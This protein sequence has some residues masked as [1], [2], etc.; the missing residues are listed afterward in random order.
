MEKKIF[1]FFIFM[2]SLFADSIGIV[3]N[4]YGYVE[5]KRGE[6]II[7]VK[8]G[9]SVKEGDLILTKAS[10]GVGIVFEDGS[11]LSLG[12]KSIFS[13]KRYLFKPQ[14]SEYDIDLKLNRGKAAFSSGKV[15]K[16]A[17]ASLK[18]R[19]PEGMVGIRG[20]KFLV[21]VK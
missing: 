10:S 12:E 17:P 19:V 4:F 21:S 7:P 15:G 14:K 11:L 16:L 8:K 2:I 6:K 9:L 18:F 20:T 3:K 13:V 1:V 5:I